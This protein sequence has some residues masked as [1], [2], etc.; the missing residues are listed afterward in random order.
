[1]RL[2]VSSSDKHQKSYTKVAEAMK[3]GKV[4]AEDGD[5]GVL[6]VTLFMMRIRSHAVNG[7]NVP[8][9]H[10]ALFLWSAM[11][12]ITTLDGICQTTKRNLV[13]ETISLMFIVMRGDITKPCYC[14]SEPGEH[15]FGDV[16]MNVREFSA[17]Q[18]ASQ[19]E[20]RHCR[21]NAIFRGDLQTSKSRGKGYR[22]LSE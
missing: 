7:K 4:H 10:R 5:V 20:K 21:A 14:T 12:W 3:N 13:A 16:R 8:S 1:M 19:V 11:I 15:V 17:S 22:G 6:V 18:F 9:Q 2:L